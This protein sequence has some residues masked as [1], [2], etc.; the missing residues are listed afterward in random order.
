MVSK[1]KRAAGNRV[2]SSVADIESREAAGRYKGLRS[3]M[4]EEGGR[5][6]RPGGSQEGTEGI[7]GTAGDTIWEQ[8]GQ[9]M[10]GEIDIKPGEGE[11]LP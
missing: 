7:D 3:E 1:R 10:V 11:C 8:L 4:A 5:E 9:Y 6:N 2:D